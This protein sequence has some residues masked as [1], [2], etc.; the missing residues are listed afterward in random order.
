MEEHVYPHMYRIEK[1][2]WWFAAR[3][4]ILLH[5]I[6]SRITTS[7]ETRVLDVGCGTGAILELFSRRFQ[8]YGTDFSPQAI[9]FCRQ[10]GLTHLF[11][12][13][14]ADYPRTE[15]F[16]LI[17]IL[18]VVEHVEDDGGL[19]AHAH[20]LLNDHGYLLIAAPAFP[21][22]WSKHDVVLHHKRR[23]TRRSLRAVVAAAGFEIE[24]LTFFNTFLFPVALAKRLVARLTGSDKA[25]DLEIPPAPLNV[26]LRNIFA[27]ESHILPHVS[28]PFGLSLLCLARR[29]GA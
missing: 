20:A 17:T 4:K 21:F 22:L 12:G 26:A 5:Y 9:E 7:K 8:A 1:E 15:R 28:L 10:R 11:L 3:Q 6:T 2:H 25:N 18:D 29:R 24:H 27:L 13:S 14:L 16:D 19:L 23:Y